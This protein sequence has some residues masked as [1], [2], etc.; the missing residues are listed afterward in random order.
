[1]AK[2]FQIAV[3]P[4]SAKINKGLVLE[5]E[6]VKEPLADFFKYL[7]KWTFSIKVTNTSRDF[8]RNINVTDYL[9][10]DKLAYI[11]NISASSG[12]ISIMDNSI[13]WHID[14]LYPG[15]SF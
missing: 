7:Q 13:I 11:K 2:D 8:I 5:K 9:L 6:L 14:G 12:T 1:M 10:F 15:E 3:H 4:S